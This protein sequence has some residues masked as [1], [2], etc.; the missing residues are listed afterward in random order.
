MLKKNNTEM[1]TKNFMIFILINKKIQIKMKSLFNTC[2][3]YWVFL[4]KK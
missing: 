4:K 3:K 2:K 1:S